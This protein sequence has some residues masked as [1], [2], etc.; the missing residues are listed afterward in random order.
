MHVGRVR[1]EDDV[2]ITKTGF[3]NLTQTPKGKEMLDIIRDGAK[4][5]HGV[6][7]HFQIK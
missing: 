7:C 3:E 2:L 5:P 4:C 6:E 1:I